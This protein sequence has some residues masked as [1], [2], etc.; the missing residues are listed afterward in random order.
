MDLHDPELLAN[1][2]PTRSAVPSPETAF[3]IIGRHG[4]AV[5]VC[6]QP[7]GA[8]WLWRKE[9]GDIGRA[10]VPFLPTIRARG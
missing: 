5:G 9:Q 8:A 3:E 4:K 10:L 1:E 6:G 2:E 7:G